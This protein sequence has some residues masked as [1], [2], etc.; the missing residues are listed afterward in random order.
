LLAGTL[1]LAG[2][3][4]VTVFTFTKSEVIFDRS[5]SDFLKRPLLD[6]IVRVD[7]VLVRGSLCKVPSRCEH[8]F[9]LA[10]R[11]LPGEG[12]Q[13]ELEV[14]Y[15][16]CVIPDTFRDVPGYEFGVVVLGEL[17]DNPRRFDA[18]TIW[19]RCPG[20]YEVPRGPAVHEA[21]ARPIPPCP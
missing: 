3:I 12:P 16:H 8:R 9:R 13:H 17:H 14:R 19:V 21:L 7:G 10:D 11:P 2:A 4:L 1:V 5:V 20:K 18:T 6:T 15:E